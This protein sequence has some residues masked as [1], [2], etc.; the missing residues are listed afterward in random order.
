V[1]VMD[2]GMVSEKNIAFLRARNAR[3]LV[4]TP[5]SQLKIF[6]KELLEKEGWQSVQ[7][8]LEAR[9]IAHPDGAGAEQF[10]LC[11]STARAEKERAMLRQQTGRL[12][13]ELEKIDASLR[14][15][16]EADIER[17][18][19]R[20]GRWLG[21]YPAAAHVLEATV[22][23]DANGAAAG[24]AIAS[25]VDQGRWKEHTHG[26]CLLRTNCTETDPAKLWRWYIQLAPSPRS[27]GPRGPGLRPAYLAPP[28][29]LGSPRPKPRSAPPKAI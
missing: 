20:I 29:A 25:R 12:C 7:D 18:G 21:K 6:E 15:A 28:S 14:R 10:V 17:F 16:P 27:V 26:A 1:W 24:L 4:G 13:A 5:K 22:E 23:R 11:R 3:Y 8:G 9:L 19:R 2:R